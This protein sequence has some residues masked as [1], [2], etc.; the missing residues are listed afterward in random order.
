MHSIALSIYKLFRKNTFLILI[1]NSTFIYCEK[2][3]FSHINKV[4]IV[5]FGHDRVEELSRHNFIKIEFKNYIFKLDSIK[6]YLKALIFKFEDNILNV[7]YR[8]EF[9][10]SEFK[11]LYDKISSR[12]HINVEL[13]NYLVNNSISSFVY[14]LNNISSNLDL[15]IT[16]YNYNAYD[17]LFQLI[18]HINRDWCI[19]GLNT[20]R[21][22]YFDGIIKLL[23]NFSHLTK[24]KHIL[25]PGA[26][27][28]RLGYELASLGFSV[29]MNEVL[30]S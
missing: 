25:I 23:L 14:G 9:V 22:L 7:G 5:M 1:F 4:Q 6:E 18:V 30:P 10:S 19:N 16:E 2:Y 12:W 26:G 27:L 17:N 28:G 13:L 29:E 3:N 11:T 8:L 15:K 21:I 20:R 24:G